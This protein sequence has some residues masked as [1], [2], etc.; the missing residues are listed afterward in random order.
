MSCSL[1]IRELRQVLQQTNGKPLAAINSLAFS[2]VFSDIEASFQR[3][4]CVVPLLV[5][6]DNGVQNIQALLKVAVLGMIQSMRLH[7]CL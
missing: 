2:N 4:V 7:F 6:L 5:L 1:G 3:A